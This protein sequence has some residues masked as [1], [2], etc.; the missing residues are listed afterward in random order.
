MGKHANIDPLP[1]PLRPKVFDLDALVTQHFRLTGET[2]RPA[3]PTGD[4]PILHAD[5][6]GGG[7]RQPLRPSPIN[8]LG[9]AWDGL[10][11]R[12][13]RRLAGRHPELVTAI[14]T[15]LERNPS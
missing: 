11:A 13:K 3:R 10:T 8:H 14:V 4:A 6:R 2:F 7:S 1:E 9:E 5:H 15:T 12:E